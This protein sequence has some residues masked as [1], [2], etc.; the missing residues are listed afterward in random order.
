MRDCISVM[1]VGLSL[2]FTNTLWASISPTSSGGVRGQFRSHVSQ[3]GERS[4]ILCIEIG[5]P[6]ALRRTPLQLCLLRAALAGRDLLLPEP[7]MGTQDTLQ[8]SSVAGGRRVRQVR[9]LGSHAGDDIVVGG[10][11]AIA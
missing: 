6:L 11:V 9:E 4:F 3:P 1:I 8:P 10:E 7:R 5:K 2:P